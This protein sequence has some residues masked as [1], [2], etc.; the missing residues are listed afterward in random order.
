MKKSSIAHIVMISLFSNYHLI[1]AEQLIV[2]FLKPYPIVANQAATEKLQK[3]LGTPGKLARHL[4]KQ[5]LNHDIAGVFATYG[6]FLQASN[7]LGEI[8]FPRTGPFIYFIVTEQL[9]PIIMSGNTIHHWELEEGVAA[10]MYK[11]E[12][13]TDPVTHIHFWDVS[14][15]A[16]PANNQIPLESIA[17][18]ANPKYVYIPLGISIFKES[19]HLILPD[20]YIKKGINLT[21][22]ALY[23]LNLAQ[24]FGPLIPLY[25]KDTAGYRQQLTY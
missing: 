16:L 22:N 11:M 4:S 13:K 5:V 9:T 24:Y 8:T 3:K 6:G 10:Q 19:P 7:L 12:Q 20:I 14:Q 18:L 15:E 23:I 1:Q 25:K 21:A 2:L 17:L